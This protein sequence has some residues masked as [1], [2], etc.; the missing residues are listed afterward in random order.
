MSLHQRKQEDNVGIGYGFNTTGDCEVT[1]IPHNNAAIVTVKCAA[2]NLAWWKCMNRKLGAGDH[3][4][5]RLLCWVRVPR[6]VSRVTASAWVPKSSWIEWWGVFKAYH[7]PYEPIRDLV[8][9]PMTAQQL[10]EFDKQRDDNIIPD[11]DE[12]AGE[13]LEDDCS[14]GSM[15]PFIL[16]EELGKAVVEQCT[17]VI[18]PRY[19]RSINKPLLRSYMKMC[20]CGKVT[21][22]NKDG[23]RMLWDKSTE[24]HEEC[25]E[26]AFY[27]V[28]ERRQRMQETRKRKR[29]EVAALE[30]AAQTAATP[31]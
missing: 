3:E 16:D 5:R 11:D 12:A 4:P 7:T 24:M 8:S 21:F 29:E 17:K 6:T 22:V 15:H 2:R 13:A 31:L 14:L 25:A 9:E 23:R 30:A 20:P 18:I 10:S 27:R 19:E 26:A 28:Q 1:D